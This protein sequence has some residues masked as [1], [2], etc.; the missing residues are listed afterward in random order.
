[1]AKYHMKRKEKEMTDPGAFGDVLKRGKYTTVA[2]CRNHEPYAVTMNYGYDETRRALYFHCARTGLK[3]D[4]IRE[5]PRVCAT[6]IE[7]L[8]Y[9]TGKCDHAYRSLVLWGTMATVEEEDEMMHALDILIQ[10]L[11]E[12]PVSVRRR[13]LAGADVLER[14][15]ILRLDIE[16]ITGKEGL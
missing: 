7:D 16:D 3:I 4:F 11:E 9:K 10:H 12:D 14:V 2:M 8:G 15:C 1:M 13:A 5:N 6:V